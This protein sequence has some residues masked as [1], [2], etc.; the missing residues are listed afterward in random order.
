MADTC[1]LISQDVL[2]SCTDVLVG[3][4]NDRLILYNKSQIASYDLNVSNE[5]IIEGI[6]MVSSPQATGYVFEGRNYSVNDSTKLK[7]GKFQAGYEHT[8]VFRIFGNTPDIKAQIEA[9]NNGL[10]VAVVQNNHTGVNGNAAFEL[11]G[12]DIGL[13]VTD[14]SQDK[15]DADSQGAWV[16]TLAT[17]ADYREPHLAATVFDTNFATT[18]AMIDATL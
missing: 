16:V 5:Q 2:N 13:K 11:K 8:T 4:V 18:K 9:M 1:G 10:I 7:N 17:P 14:L 15:S 6:N 12:K 3:G